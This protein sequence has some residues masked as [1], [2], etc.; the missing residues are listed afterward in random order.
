MTLQEIIDSLELEQFGLVWDEEGNAVLNAY[1]L[2]EG[3]FNDICNFCYEEAD[4]SLDSLFVVTYFFSD[5]KTL[6]IL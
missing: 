2:E 5:G 1:D 6:A 3:M 4:E